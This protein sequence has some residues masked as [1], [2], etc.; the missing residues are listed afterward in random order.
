MS[1]KKF[2]KIYSNLSS[3]IQE[4]LEPTAR[5]SGEMTV[6]H[7]LLYVFNYGNNSYIPV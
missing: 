3:M 4:I 7:I 5:F 6:V 2:V 1:S